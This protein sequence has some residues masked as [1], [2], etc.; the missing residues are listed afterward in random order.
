MSLTNVIKDA[1]NLTNDV[2]RLSDNVKSLARDIRETQQKQTEKIAKFWLDPVRLQ[3]S[4][5][6]NRKEIKQIHGI[7]EERHSELLEA[8]N[9]YFSS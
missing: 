5:G 4:G 7:I 9:D 3:R 6:F 8:W 1:I 2:A